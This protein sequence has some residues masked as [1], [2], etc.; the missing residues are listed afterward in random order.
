MGAEQKNRAQEDGRKVRAPRRTRRRERRQRRSLVGG[1]QEGERLR[2]HARAPVAEGPARARPAARAR[3]SNQSPHAHHSSLCAWHKRGRHPNHSAC[4]PNGSMVATPCSR[5]PDLVRGAARQGHHVRHGGQRL[6]GPDRSL[7]L[8]GPPCS[9][10]RRQAAASPPPP[11]SCRDSLTPAQRGAP[12]PCRGS[13]SRLT[14]ARR[15][16]PRRL[17]QE[18]GRARP[19]M[20][21]ERYSQ[22]LLMYH[23][24][25]LLCQ[26]LHSLCDRYVLYSTFFNQSAAF[27]D[28]QGHLQPSR[29]PSFEGISQL[30][31]TLIYN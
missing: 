17:T 1:T 30:Y 15:S 2:V 23:P 6:A 9:C 20:P 29:E 14:P 11:R 31:I 10:G 12:Q 8:S 24:C 5:Q 18:S 26:R 25:A 27:R 22:Y 7:R 3:A 28:R 16:V 21:G 19:A 4:G 13:D